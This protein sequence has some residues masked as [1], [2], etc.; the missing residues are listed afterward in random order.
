MRSLVW[1]RGGSVVVGRCGSD[2]CGLVV[3]ISGFSGGV[4]CCWISDWGRWLAGLILHL[5]VCVY[6]SVFQSFCEFGGYGGGD[7]GGGCGCGGVL[8]AMNL[9]FEFFF[10]F[11]WVWWL[12]WW[13]WWFG[14]FCLFVGLIVGCDWNG[15]LVAVVVV[16]M[17][18]AVVAVLGGG[19]FFLFLALECGWGCCWW[20]RG[21]VIEVTVAG[22]K[23]FAVNIF[24][25]ILM[26]FLYIIWIN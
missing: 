13:C 7:G 22:W 19:L 25:F 9:M 4:G 21:V 17:L 8:V 20:R 10:F 2:L 18:L 5:G 3:W 16:A 15:G 1:V 6:R 26:I 12:C 14:F 24:Y 11:L 23:V